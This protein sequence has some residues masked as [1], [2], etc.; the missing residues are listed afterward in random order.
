LFSKAVEVKIKQLARE[1]EDKKGKAAK[2]LENII[3]LF[4]QVRT[5]GWQTH[6]FLYSI[7]KTDR[8]EDV[9]KL[10]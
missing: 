2:M 3:D 8:T 4:N 5:D 10:H 6:S 9:Y 7:Q 1:L